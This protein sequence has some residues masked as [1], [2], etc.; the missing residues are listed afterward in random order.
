M[1]CCYRNFTDYVIDLRS[2]YDIKEKLKPTL[3]LQTLHT[4]RNT[5]AKTL[6]SLMKCLCKESNNKFVFY[7]LI[8]LYD[9][10]IFVLFR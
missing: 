10:G 1:M 5:I 3:V 7:M 8:K 4:R 9:L 2:F 6:G